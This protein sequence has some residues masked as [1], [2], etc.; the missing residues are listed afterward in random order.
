MNLRRHVKI[1]CQRTLILLHDIKGTFEL[2]QDYEL[3]ICW[4][5]TPS[6]KVVVG[7]KNQA[8]KAWFFMC[9]KPAVEV[10]LTSFTI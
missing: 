8:I 4:N 6:Y 1:Q 3:P 7:I 9:P 5:L 2:Y 10:I